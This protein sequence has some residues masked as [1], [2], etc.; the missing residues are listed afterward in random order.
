LFVS[1]DRS[2]DLYEDG[3]LK[4]Y[5]WA[6]SEIKDW[7]YSRDNCVIISTQ[8]FDQGIDIPAMNA[9]VLAIGTKRYRRA[10]QR[11]GR[12]LRPKE[13]SNEVYV[14]DFDDRT[15]YFLENHSKYRRWIYAMEGFQVIDTS[16]DLEEMVGFGVNFDNLL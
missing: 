8:V 13:G 3:E 10:I 7:V 9:M 1:G 15:H 11:I 14:L 4:A 5:K 2:V 16:R 6:I 12:I